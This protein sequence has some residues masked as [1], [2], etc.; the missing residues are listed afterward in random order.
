[1]VVAAKPKKGSPH[2]GSHAR[3]TEGVEVTLDILWPPC[4]AKKR[5]LRGACR[6]AQSPAA[7][8]VA[9]TPRAAAAGCRGGGARGCTRTVRVK[10]E[11]EAE[12]RVFIEAKVH[13]AA[14]A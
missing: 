1:M 11:C 8:V 4:Q 14:A 12:L 7:D 2:G 3:S 5:P 10:L 13:E 6:E 9:G